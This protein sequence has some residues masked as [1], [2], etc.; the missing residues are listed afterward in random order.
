MPGDD[1]IDGSLHDSP[2]ANTGSRK[3]A[4]TT[5]ASSVL[6]A[7]N[8]VHTTGPVP[9][10]LIAPTVMAE[11]KRLGGVVSEV[12]VTRGGRHMYGITVVVRE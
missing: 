8:G 10:Y 5:S 9:L 3:T 12:H 6:S 1:R 4:T 11:V 7:S 2:C